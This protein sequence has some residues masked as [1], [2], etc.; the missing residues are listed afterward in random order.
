VSQSYRE[1]FRVLRPTYRKLV[2]VCAGVVLAGVPV[3]AIGYWSSQYVERLGQ[4][5][6]SLAAKRAIALSEKRLGSVIAGLNDL[7]DRD[8]TSC[9]PDHVKAMHQTAFAVSPIKELAIVNADGETLCTNLGI[10]LGH[11]D[12]LSRPVTTSGDAFVIEVVR[13]DGRDEPM[14]RIR[15]I[16]SIGKESLAALVPADLLLPKVSPH[17]GPFPIFLR[18]TTR[19]GTLIEE[20]GAALAEEEGSDERIVVHVRSNDY[21]LAVLASTSLAAVHASYL[22]IR[23]AGPAA[24]LFILLLVFALR[25]YTRYRENPVVEIERGLKANEFVPY[26]QPI[27][28]ITSGRLIGAEVLVRWRKSDGTVVPPASFIPLAESSGLIFEL[29]RALMKRVS[30]E[31]GTAIG[32]RPRLMVSFNMTAAHFQDEATIALVDDLF[33]ASPIALSQ[34]V[35]EVTE[36]QP[37]ENLATA[38]RVVEGLQAHGVRIAIDDVGTGHGG[39][40]YLLKLGVDILKIDKLFVDAIGTERYSTTIIKSLCELARGMRMEII[41]EGVETFEQVAYLRDHGVR[42]AQGYVFAPP[43]PCASFLKLLEAADPLPS[44]ATRS[45]D[46]LPAGPPRQAPGP[47]VAAA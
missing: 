23:L 44:A 20:S 43:L 24:G 31:A 25:A 38:R 19:D 26:F 36:R 9:N 6:V 8:V 16:V 46:G 45:A 40:S 32:Q 37:L 11:R 27:L 28:D 34:L 17:V 33:A 18:L 13:I 5:E 3:A 47:R 14:V 1:A 39:L 10:P 21:G 30:A 7:A 4:E 42:Y 41:A 2:A 29:T 12:I 22:G 15:R 35:L